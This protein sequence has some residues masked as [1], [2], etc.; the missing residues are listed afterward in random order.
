MNHPKTRNKKYIDP[1]TRNQCW[2]DLL[3]IYNSHVDVIKNG[4]KIAS[5]INDPAMV[6]QI[7]TKNP[8][9]LETLKILERDLATYS[10]SL[11]TIYQKHNTRTGGDGNPDRYMEAMAIGNEYH[12]W[13]ESYQAVL[14][15]NQMLVTSELTLL[16][17]GI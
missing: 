1:A 14:F 16:S 7:K 8:G 11:T 12:Q 6:Q 10:Q 9:L 17:N 3:R 15:P 13:M 5:V 2:T 4:C